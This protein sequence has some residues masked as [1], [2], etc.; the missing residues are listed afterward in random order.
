MTALHEHPTV[1]AALLPRA[2]PVKT[3]RG[4]YGARFV[5]PSG[6]PSVYWLANDLDTIC[7][8]IAVRLGLWDDM[9]WDVESAPR[10]EFVRHG[11][12][13]LLMGRG[14]SRGEWMNFSSEGPH[15]DIPR[16]TTVPEL[17][18]YNGERQALPASKHILTH[19]LEQA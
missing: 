4:P 2:Q 7:R 11:E 5:E 12:W 15:V 13:S 6:S 10:L 1:R 3:V 19:L 16:R 8:L 17:D 14:T 9:R 18:A